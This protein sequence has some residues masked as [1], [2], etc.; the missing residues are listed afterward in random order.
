ML[1][2]LRLII[3]RHTE[4]YTCTVYTS[5]HDELKVVHI[6]HGGDMFIFQLFGFST[7]KGGGGKEERKQKIKNEGNFNLIMRILLDLCVQC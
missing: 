7:E 5:A 3:T 2:Y 1:I 6:D 4:K